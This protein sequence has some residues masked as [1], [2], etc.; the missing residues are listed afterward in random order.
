MINRTFST[1]TVLTNSIKRKFKEYLPPFF[2]FQVLGGVPNMEAFCQNSLRLTG[3]LYDHDI[4][5]QRSS[6][7]QIVVLTI[8][9][10]KYA[11]ELDTLMKIGNILYLRSCPLKIVE[12][13]IR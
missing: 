13:T 9:Q 4:K 8:L 3:W 2:S 11:S 12:E 1:L 5:R 7:S 10:L 6:P